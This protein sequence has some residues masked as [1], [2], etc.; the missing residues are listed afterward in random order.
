MH[1]G[2]VLN[3]NAK[4]GPVGIHF[5]KRDPNQTGNLQSGYFG[6]RYFDQL[7]NAAIQ[8]DCSQSVGSIFAGHR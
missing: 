4:K 5:L 2:I 7:Q 8:A 1:M 6:D 3:G